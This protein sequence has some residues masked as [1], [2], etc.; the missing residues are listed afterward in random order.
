MLVALVPLGYLTAFVAHWA[1]GDANSLHN[2]LYDSGT[3]KP[4]DSRS[5][6]EVPSGSGI[7]PP[8]SS[9]HVATI[10]MSDVNVATD[11][12]RE[13]FRSYIRANPACLYSPQFAD[14]EY[15]SST[16]QYMLISISSAAVKSQGADAAMKARE[17]CELQ[18]L[19]AVAQLAN[20]Q[21]TSTA[22]L[23]HGVVDRRVNMVAKAKVDPPHPIYEWRSQDGSV[24]TI[25]YGRI[26]DG[27]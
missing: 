24:L 8:R 25:L 6:G 18:A 7:L 21:L 26:D 19:S 15:L 3:L 11:A 12:I 4:S 5:P 13:P 16:Q 14:I 22:D 10:S 2:H 20:N 23:S 17:A 9:D 1:E 27:R